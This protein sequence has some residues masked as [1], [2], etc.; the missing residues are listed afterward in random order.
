MCLYASEIRFCDSNSSARSIRDALR[1]L[2]ENPI[3]AVFAEI[4]PLETSDERDLSPD[5]YEKTI[6]Q[7][8]QELA[9]VLR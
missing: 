3:D 6:R 4:D 8:L 9:K 7:N 5:L 1:G 2:K